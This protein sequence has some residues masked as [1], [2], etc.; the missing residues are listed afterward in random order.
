MQRLF[1]Q[2]AAS[3]SSPLQ[4]LHYRISGDFFK[5]TGNKSLPSDLILPKIEMPNNQ[6]LDLKRLHALSITSGFVKD[7]FSASR[8]VEYCLKLD[9]S[10]AH[11]I[12]NTIERPDVYTWN[13]MIKG[14]AELD[15]PHISVA[16]FFRMLLMRV[17]PS[18]YTF[19][20]IVKACILVKDTFLGKK[21]HG[22]IL[23]HGVEDILVVKNSLLKM[24]SSIGSLY[25]ACLLFD[26]SFILDTISWNS[27][28]SGY[29]KHGDAKSARTLFDKMQHRNL[30]S[31]S[32][33]IDCYVRTGDFAEALHLFNKMLDSGI[34][35]DAISLVS[36]LKVCANLGELDKGR[37][38]HK[39]VEQNR[40]MSGASVIL[41]TALIDMYCKCGCIDMALKLFYEMR[42]TDIV[43]CNSVINGLAKHGHGQKAMELFWE[44]RQLGIVPNESTF[45]GLLCACS[46]SG[47]LLEGRKLFKLMKEEYGLEPKIEHYGCLA[48]LLGRAGLVYEAEE[49]LTTM[50]MEPEAKHWGAL[51]AACRTHNNVEL[52]EHIG[53]HLLRL[54]P[55]DGGRYIQLSNVY[56][57]DSRWDDAFDTRRAMEDQGIKKDWGRS[58]IW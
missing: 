45:V 11:N 31:W 41:G 20:L 18:D 22:Q 1:M 27:M 36:M 10:Y 44:M 29:G 8:L 47:L 5:N 6:T 39:Y 34:E 55:H 50:P 46:H 32:A 16:Y 38:I 51:L 49:V 19:A 2:T 3:I 24:Y 37:W 28:I 15:C 43:L 14:L 53:K 35:P 57:G 40:L 52:G 7:A 26:S 9:P 54:E 25:D 42:K 30:V 33:M 58:S 17:P 23:K 12:F 13:A 56:V 21:V 48:D 4:Y